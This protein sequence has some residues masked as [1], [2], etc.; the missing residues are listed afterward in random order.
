MDK[1]N[2]DNRMEAALKEDAAGLSAL[3]SE[4]PASLRSL[5]ASTPAATTAGVGVT[6]ISTAKLLSAKFALWSLGGLLLG[7]AGYYALTS[8][9]K[10]PINSQP[11]P[12]LKPIVTAVDTP[13]PV[14]DSAPRRTPVGIRPTAKQKITYSQAQIDSMLRAR[15]EPV[16]TLKDDGRIHGEFKKK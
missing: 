2:I 5:I 16:N 4:V 14:V 15:P 7:S 8:P 11:E 12:T 1:H 13:K 6:A 3:S 9:D 10:T